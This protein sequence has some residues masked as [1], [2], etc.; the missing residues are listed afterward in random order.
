MYFAFKFF[1]T[2]FIIGLG[3]LFFYYKQGPYEVKEVCFGDVCPDNGG[4]FLVYK[5]QYSKEECESIGAK[6]I[7]GIGWSEVYAG[8]SPDNFF[9]RFADAIYEL[10]K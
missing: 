9:S 1:F 3:V 6:P 5:K 7:V 10:R 8:C 2:L 4:T